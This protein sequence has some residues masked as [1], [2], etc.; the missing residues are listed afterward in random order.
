MV[1]NIECLPNRRGPLKFAH[2]SFRSQ[3]LLARPALVFGRHP[4]ATARHTTK[5]TTC[6]ARKLG[7]VQLC[8]K[9]LPA[10][11]VHPNILD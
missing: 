9:V 5:T 2:P 4:L 10:S 7:I 11:R 1:L 6:I 8:S 3:C